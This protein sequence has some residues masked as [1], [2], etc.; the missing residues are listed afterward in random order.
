[1]VGITNV[2]T[3][4]DMSGQIELCSDMFVVPF[5]VNTLYMY[6]EGYEKMCNMA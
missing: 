3:W 2:R 4:P 1:M 6:L 5:L